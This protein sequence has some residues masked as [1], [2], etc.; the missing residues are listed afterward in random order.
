MAY[1]QLVMHRYFEDLLP[2]AYG[3]L[4]NWIVFSIILLIALVAYLIA[5]LVVLRLVKAF[6]MRTKTDWDEMLFESRFFSRIAQ[7]VPGSI[8]SANASWAFQKGPTAAT[9]EAFARVYILIMAILAVNS[10]LNA[11]ERILR[12]YDVSRKLPVRGFAQ[13]AKIILFI[14]GLILVVSTIAGQS[15]TVIFGGLGALTAVLMLVFKDPILGLVGG[16]QLSAN[17]MVR[18]GD[19]IEMP[20]YGADGTVTEVALTT[21]KV[22]NWDRTISMVP[23]YSLISDSF[24]NWRG[25]EDSGGRRIKRCI[26]L[27]INT[28]QLVTTD[29]LNNFK[30]I[31]L[32][33]NYLE[34][35]EK[36]IAEWNRR[37]HGEKHRVNARALTNIGTFRAYVLAYLRHHPKVRQDFTLLVRQLQ[38]TTQGLPLE[39]YLFTNDTRWAYYEDIQADIFDHLYAILPEFGLRAYQA[40]TG[41][42]ITNFLAAKATDF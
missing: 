7:I 20:K 38:P 33:T 21:V 9:I 1:P 4:S 8:I 3:Y 10:A 37:N 36:E 42:D 6:V 31:G 28:I 16:I 25:M 14:W 26:N 11:M 30:Q 27:D 18:K 29:Q 34:Q 32:L 5:K 35:K 40:P 19:W 13:V 12:R 17:D 22:E 2:P 15:P 39:V 23:T 41:N 24:R